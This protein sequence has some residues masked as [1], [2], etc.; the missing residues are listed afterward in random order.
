MVLAYASLGDTN[1]WRPSLEPEHLSVLENFLVVMVVL[2]FLLLCD[3]FLWQHAFWSICAA[4]FVNTL[5]SSGHYTS[6]SSL[7]LNPH[8]FQMAKYLSTGK[9]G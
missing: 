2:G 7:Y 6:S 1:A 9:F 3:S 8:L 4:L 5:T